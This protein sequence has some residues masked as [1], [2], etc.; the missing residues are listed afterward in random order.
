MMST[1]TLVTW[2]LG[3]LPCALL[4]IKNSQYL[5]NLYH[6]PN[7]VLRTYIDSLSLYKISVRW[8][9]HYR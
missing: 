1:K 5:H 4:V 7:T 8:V 2:G 6:V 9:P 3:V